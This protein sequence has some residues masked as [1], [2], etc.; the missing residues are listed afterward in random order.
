M[1]VVNSSCCERRWDHVGQVHFWHICAKPRSKSAKNMKKKDQCRVSSR[2]CA[3]KIV[4]GNSQTLIFTVEMS[5]SMRCHNARHFLESWECS[6]Y[7]G[8][9][10]VV[11][12]VVRIQKGKVERTQ[13]YQWRQASRTRATLVVKA[14]CWCKVVSGRR[15]TFLK[16]H[17]E[18]RA[19]DL[20]D[21]FSVEAAVQDPCV[22]LSVQGVYK[23]S[24]QRI[25][26]RDLIERSLFKLSINDLQA[27]PLLSP[28]G[29]CTR[30]PKEVSWQD[31]NTRSL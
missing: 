27:R 25:F 14:W 1:Y 17:V 23:R 30:S 15:D 10:R 12:R 3:Q 29:L 6:L 31:L 20:L 9:L 8:C 24:P 16:I 4:L 21:R 2:W 19:Q 7:H 26:A 22:R 18:D 11:H 13:N 28:P 5:K